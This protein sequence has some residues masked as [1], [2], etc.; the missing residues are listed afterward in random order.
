MKPSLS[1][2][3]LLATFPQANK[4]ALLWMNVALPYS[5]I[6][7]PS[8]TPYC[9]LLPPSN[10]FS[11]LLYPLAPPFLTSGGFPLAS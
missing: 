5:F 7:F 6:C 8:T 2:P 10:P 4:L 9:L 11:S 1:S 3:C